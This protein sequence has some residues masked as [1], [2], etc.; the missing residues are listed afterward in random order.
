MRGWLKPISN[1]KNWN[2][3]KLKQCLKLKC[4]S[5]FIKFLVNSE[6]GQLKKDSLK[7]KYIET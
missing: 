1:K 7:I 5:D 2:K 4:S 6:N 3:K